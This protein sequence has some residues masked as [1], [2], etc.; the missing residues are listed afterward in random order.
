MKHHYGPRFRA[1]HWCTEQL[2]SSALAQMDLTSAQGH[3]MGF[4]ARQESPPCCRDIEEAFHLSHPTVCGTLNRM[5][6]KG[7][8][9]VR[10][11]END[12]RI[13]RI[14]VLPKGRQ[15]QVR[16]E[17]TIRQIEDRVTCGF[18]PEERE[19]FSLFL[20]RAME[21]LGANP[22]PIPPLKEEL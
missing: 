13:K 21:N 10:P 12:R 22:E 9:Q 8:I 14:H 18:T 17:E 7:F 15:C 3:I 1:L 19:L 2:M 20:N 6:K 11:D 5:A 4:L 16:M